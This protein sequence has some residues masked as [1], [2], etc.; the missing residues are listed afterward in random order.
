MERMSRP[1][2]ARDHMMAAV[3]DTKKKKKEC[4]KGGREAKQTTKISPKLVMT[5]IPPVAIH[6]R[7]PLPPGEDF[8]I[9]IGH[10][11][12]ATEQPGGSQKNS[13]L[14]Y[15]L[16]RHGRIGM[17]LD[18]ARCSH[19]RFP[20]RRAIPND[21]TDAFARKYN[22]REIQRPYAMASSA[23]A[24]NLRGRE[25]TRKRGLRELAC[26]GIGNDDLDARSK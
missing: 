10:G 8:L 3:N 15:A 24:E 18:S 5:R 17:R 26:W 6:I 9:Q 23:V 21:F 25:L 14:R 11:W 22:Q 16:L 1:A 20:I 4:R 7:S 2:G 12:M 13:L 19:G